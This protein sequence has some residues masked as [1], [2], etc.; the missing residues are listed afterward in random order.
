M[1]G[2]SQKRTPYHIYNIISCIDRFN[3]IN[4][5]SCIVSHISYIH[6]RS[7]KLCGVGY[8]SY[9]RKDAKR[10]KPCR[11][12]ISSDFLCRVLLLVYF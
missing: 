9:K 3:G 12:V 2:K 1:S 4:D 10:I 7:C 5:L 6:P 8:F 11:Y